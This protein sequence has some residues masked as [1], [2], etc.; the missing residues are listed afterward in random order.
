MVLLLVPAVVL[1]L[2]VSVGVVDVGVGVVVVVVVV[3]VKLVFLLL[4]SISQIATGVPYST[5]LRK[6]V[7]SGPILTN[8]RFNVTCF[9]PVR[10]FDLLRWGTIPHHSLPFIRWSGT[11]TH[12]HTHT[13]PHVHERAHEG[14]CACV[15][16][17]S[18]TH[19]L[20]P[21]GLKYSG[22]SASSDWRKDSIIR[23]MGCGASRYPVSDATSPAE[24]KDGP[25]VP[26]KHKQD[27]L[28][29]FHSFELLQFQ[30]PI[31]CCNITAVAYAFSVVLGQ[32]ITVN[33]IFHHA[34]LPC[35]F[36]VCDGMTLAE[37]F[38]AA[39]D[40]AEGLGEVYVEAYFFDQE[41]VSYEAFKADLLIDMESNHDVLIANFSV[42][43][44]HQWDQG[45]GH[46]ALI[47]HVDTAGGPNGEQDD[48]SVT[49]CETHPLKYG[50]TWVVNSRHLYDAMVD[51]DG[52]AKRA[53]GLLR[54]ARASCPRRNL[55]GL[56][57]A[58][59]SVC[60]CDPEH[61]HAKRAWLARWSKGIP[62]DRFQMVLN[63][64]SITA[65]ALGITGL[66]NN[67]QSSSIV[68]PDD[69][70]RALKLNYEEELHNN[71]SPMEVKD[72]LVGYSEVA[73]LPHL[74]AESRPLGNSAD[75]LLE[76]LVAAVGP[77][78]IRGG[79]ED[80]CAL[81]VF[82]L[83]VAT[84]TTLIFVD[85]KSE[86]AKIS[87]FARHWAVV[88]EVDA[89]GRAVT[90]ADPRSKILTRLW[91]TSV[92]LLFEAAEKE[93]AKEFVVVSLSK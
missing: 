81:L 47:G 9:I 71:H 75:A 56:A 55:T 63:M 24:V 35:D 57:A 4:C 44:A 45:G 93:L 1:A 2:V 21:F 42:R 52:D 66:L 89:G 7:E 92:D 32:T 19:T 77:A 11:H 64:G 79:A 33:D 15:H 65:M 74:R 31:N 25:K 43:I 40:I 39:S 14:A 50:K 3:A 48:Y 17:Y 5:S 67:G 87:K 58:Q 86:A 37:T 82:D 62:A 76:A 18:S 36:V 72:R 29:K 90:L 80:A 78:G 69:I 70:M 34:R 41:K 83:N 68:L 49:I 10:S 20:Q 28:A 38:V 26:D 60:Y 61:S 85:P 84:G 12:T 22:S 6:T 46:F 13:R 27:K 54:V 59:S 23:F 91:S 16:V 53:R 51:K 30:Q 88:V 8:I 73:A